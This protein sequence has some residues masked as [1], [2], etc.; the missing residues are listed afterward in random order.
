MSSGF[1]SVLRTNS[2]A[3]SISLRSMVGKREFTVRVVNRDR[4]DRAAPLTAP[5]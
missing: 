5:G 3:R 4:H 2:R 1:G